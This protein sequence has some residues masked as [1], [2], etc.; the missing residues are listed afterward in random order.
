MLKFINSAQNLKNYP[1]LPLIQWCFELVGVANRLQVFLLDFNLLLDQLKMPLVQTAFI[2]V[3]LDN[4]D[5]LNQTFFLF[6]KVF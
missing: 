2:H 4:F 6:D 3:I 1:N 5:F